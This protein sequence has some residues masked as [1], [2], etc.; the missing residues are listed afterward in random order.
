MSAAV[1]RDVSVTWKGTEIKGMREKKINH[2]DEPIDI[3]TGEDAGVQT[4]LTS[5]GQDSIELSLTGVSKDDVLKTDWFSGG[6]ARQGALVITYPNGATLSG[7]FQLSNFKEGAPYK[8]AITFEVTLKSSGAFT[9]T[10]G[11]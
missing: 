10:P 6:S 2:N 8:D 1:G 9:F 7:T 11:V 5:S 3:T 4:L